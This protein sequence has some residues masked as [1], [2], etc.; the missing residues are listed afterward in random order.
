MDDLVDIMGIRVEMRINLNSNSF[1][2]SM[3]FPYKMDY[4]MLKVF[5]ALSDSTDLLLDK[6]EPLF[7]EVLKKLEPSMKIFFHYFLLQEKQ[8]FV[9]E[10]FLLKE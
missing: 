2:Q 3:S 4:H 6:S 9:I 5:R 10:D 8:S 1:L 7:S